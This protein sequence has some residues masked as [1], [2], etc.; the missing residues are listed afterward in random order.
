MIWQVALAGALGAGLGYLG[1][2]LAPRWLERRPRPWT[3]PVLAA[4]NAGFTALLAAAHPV[5]GPYF[6]HHLL[7]IAIL[8][9]AAYVD[10]H[11]R[12]IPNELVLF[13]LAAGLLVM[14][15]SPYP[16]K[17]WVQALSGG[18][19]GFGFLFL[20]AVIVPGGMGM[21]D[22]KLAAVMGLFMGLNYIGM[23]MIFSFLIGG[24]VSAGML[25]ARLVGRKGHLP[26]GP[27]LALGSII[28]VLYGWEIWVWYIGRY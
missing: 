20:L 1:G 21:G 4:V 16:E 5:T 26:F 27:F 28:T 8:T 12:I 3:L 9:T 2:W 19:A 24:A 14:L 17:S 22:V 23:G 15:L 18:A 25:L 13:G 6:W 7:F 11:E 10:L